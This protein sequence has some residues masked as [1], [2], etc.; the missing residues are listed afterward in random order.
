MTKLLFLDVDGVLNSQATWEA[1]VAGHGCHKSGDEA[2]CPELMAR[3]NR[4][5]EV[6]GAQV[7]ICSSW[8]FNSVTRTAELFK[9]RGLVG[10]VIGC[11]PRLENYKNGMYQGRVRGD[12]IQAWLDSYITPRR[13]VEAFVIIDD[14][15]EMSTVKGHLVLTDADVGITDADV[16]RALQILG[17]PVNVG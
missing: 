6:S 7:V 4:L 16:E 2:V 11:T 10:R 15:D 1:M 8:R 9:K 12:E 14:N 3:V 13:P 17:V 5:I